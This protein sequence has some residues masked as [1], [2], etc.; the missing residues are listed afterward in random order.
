MFGL[1][2]KKTLKP[3]LSVED[4]EWVEK[5][6]LWFIETFGL[7]KVD[8][9]PF[10]LPSA[11]RFPYDDF[12]SQD[13]FKKLFEQLCNYWDVDYNDITVKFFDDIKSKQWST[14]T[15]A[16]SSNQ[17]LGVLYKTYDLTEK[18]FNMQLAK[19]NLNNAQLLVTVIAHELAHVKLLGNGLLSINDPEMEPLTDLASI[20]FGFGIFMANTCQR[21]D[22]NWISRSGYLP[23]EVISYANALMCYIT[24]KNG[25]SFH[26]FFNENTKSL[27]ENDLAFLYKTNDTLLTKY[28]VREVEELYKLGMQVS[29]GFDE[30]DFN[31]S[32]EASY[33]LLKLNPKNIAAFNNIGYALLQQKKYKEA[34]EMFTKAIDIDPYWDYPYSNRGYCKLQLEDIENGFADIH[35]SLEMN[36]E[37]S[38]AWR[39]MGVY[40]LKINDYEKAISHFEEAEK[41]DPNTD[42]INLYLSQ[43]NMKMG[44]HDKAS[45]YLKKS[46]EL[47]EYNDSTIL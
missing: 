34:I 27:F 17:P 40:Y 18:S 14:W 30:K 9:Q 16:G 42:L 47:K 8:Q 46:E 2:S 36:P 6:M 28:K 23:N 5:N 29:E 45:T 25:D 24:D 3:A 21:R 12:T 19:S 39:N 7:A 10:I 11:E 41:I 22:I 20:F 26:S 32:I 38:F 4:K 44:N 31:K 37:N 33:S 13:Q 1:F 35:S 43:A 15:L